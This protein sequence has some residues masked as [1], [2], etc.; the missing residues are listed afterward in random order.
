MNSGTSRRVST[1]AVVVISLFSFA[2]ILGATEKTAS[3]EGVVTRIDRP[4]FSFEDMLI[5]EAGTA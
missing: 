2:G 1:V 3:V 4:D 5:R